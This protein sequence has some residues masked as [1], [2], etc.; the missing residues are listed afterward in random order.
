MRLLTSPVQSARQNILK[1]S[2]GSKRMIN[3][4]VPVEL[5]SKL[6]L[7]ICIRKSETSKRESKIF[8]D[9]CRCSLA[10]TVISENKSMNF[11]EST[12]I[13]R[14]LTINPPVNKQI[15]LTRN[16]LFLFQFPG[17]GRATDFGVIKI[18]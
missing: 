17:C 5:S 9:N 1:K 4:P 18:K 13:L 10:K 8:S 12:T 3:S 7:R 2:V 14:E 6:I 16:S 11:Y 15:Q